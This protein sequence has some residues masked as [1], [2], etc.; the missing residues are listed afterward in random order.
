MT[1]AGENF[2]LTTLDSYGDFAGSN[3]QA[4]INTWVANN[5]FLP[6]SLK[7]EQVTNGSTLEID[8]DMT[9]TT[10]AVMDGT[11]EFLVP[12]V[13]TYILL[14]ATVMIDPEERLSDRL[15]IYLALFIFPPTFI[16]SIQAFLPYRVVF[17]FL[18]FF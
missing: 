15:T 4:L 5:S 12:I 2:S 14:V 17:H 6:E 3:R 9:K 18:N 8:L 16:F 7:T 11:L 13:A 10:S 1:P